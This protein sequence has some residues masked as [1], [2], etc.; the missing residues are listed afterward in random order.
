MCLGEVLYYI[1]TSMKTMK[2]ASASQPW[3]GASSL[4]SSAMGTSTSRV[5]R[6]QADIDTYAQQLLQHAAEAVSSPD[7]SLGPYVTSVLRETDPDVPVIQ[8]TEYESLRELIQEQCWVDGEKAANLIHQIATAVRQV[9]AETTTT[10]LI[11]SPTA[12]NDLIPGNLWGEEEQEEAR[13]SVLPNMPLHSENETQPQQVDNYKTETTATTIDP[14]L[15]EQAFESCVEILLSMNP[16]IAEPAA[17][18]ALSMVQGDVNWGQYLID[19]ALSAPPVCRHL[20]NDGCYRRDCQYSHDIKGHTCVFWMRGRCGKGEACPFKHGFDEAALQAVLPPAEVP[21]DESTVATTEQTE[22][23]PPL[24]APDASGGQRTVDSSRRGGQR[25]QPLSVWGRTSSSSF[26][27][28]AS[29]GAPS[30][31]AFPSL[32]T[33]TAASGW[34]TTAQNIRRVDI[35][36]DLWHAHENRD[37]AVFYIN[38][39]LE[40]YHAVAATVRRKNVIDL[41]FQSTKTFATVLETVLPQKLS[42]N[43]QVWVVT[44]T[45]H[46]VGS[47][48]HQKGGGALENAVI[49]WLSDHCYRFARGRDRNG[50]GG[51]LLV[52]GE[53]MH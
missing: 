10:E 18:Q 9:A 43:D 2:T 24:P 50:I 32:S 20:L 47:R 13:F 5:Y 51:A 41:H 23:D 26:A 45:G 15:A 22:K 27:Q 3:G 4:S 25:P 39:P 11:V 34:K 7:S 46:H 40:R 29:Q 30:G 33:T 16:D 49:E 12:E 52:F 8:L 31:S 38:N 42:E 1:Q 37:A 36:Q 44:G 17:R 14:Y 48:T 19:V 6:S 21:Q 28:V 35:P 53:N